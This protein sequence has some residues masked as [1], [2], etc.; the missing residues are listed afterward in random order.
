MGEKDT[1]CVVHCAMTDE[2]GDLT[3]NDIIRDKKSHR[4]RKY[5]GHKE[6]IILTI[7]LHVLGIYGILRV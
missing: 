7:F 3:L 1:S 2:A 4:G 6:K 5:L